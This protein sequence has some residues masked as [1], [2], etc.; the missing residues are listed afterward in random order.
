MQVCPQ[1]GCIAG[2]A[3]PH[4]AHARRAVVFARPRA[5]KPGR[6]PPTRRCPC[7]DGLAV[8]APPASSQRAARWPSPS[9]PPRWRRAM[10]PTTRRRR[11][12]RR[13]SPP[14]SRAPCSSPSTTTSIYV[15]QAFAGL[16]TKLGPGGARTDIASN[17]GGEIAGVD[18]GRRHELFYT[19]QTADQTGT[20][21]AAALNRLHGGTSSVVADLFL[22]ETMHNVDQKNHYGFQTI[23]PGCAAQ[24]PAESARRSTRDS[25]DSIR[26]PSP[27][28]GAITTSPTRR[29]TPSTT[30][31]RA[32]TSGS[33]ACCRPSRP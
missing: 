4:M 30:S 32:A 25:I 16:L 28:A 20:V 2:G 21:T 7:T 11:R 9:R 17:P 23:D 33:C 10:P 8:S 26:T 1:V 29:P 19:T 5:G 13:R 27:S 14:V 15:S 6:E 12:S 24:L 18:V 31:A 3:P 22:Y